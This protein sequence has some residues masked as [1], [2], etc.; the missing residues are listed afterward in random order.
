MV[1]VHTPISDCSTSRRRSFAQSLAIS[2]T[3]ANTVGLNAT[4]S[5]TTSA[6]CCQAPV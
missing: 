2:V 5:T 6:L 1:S 4:D 3:H